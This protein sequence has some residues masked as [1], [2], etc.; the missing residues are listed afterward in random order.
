M[1]LPLHVSCLVITLLCA[2]CG[3]E[4]DHRTAPLLHEAFVWQRVWTPEV[5]AAVSTAT[6]QR[7]HVLAAEVHF[8]GV[9]PVVTTIEPNWEA[10][11]A[12]Q[13]DVGAVI[14]IHTS[15]AAT[16]WDPPACEAMTE[17]VARIW[18]LFDEAKRPA[19]EIQ[20]D[21]DC[22][23]SK[24]KDYT[25]LVVHLRQALPA[26]TLRITA[27]PSWLRHRHHDLSIYDLLRLS[28]GYVLQVHSLHLPQGGRSTGLIDYEETKAAIAR[29]VEIG[30]PFR[31]A[32]PTYSCVVE[33]AENGRVKEVHGEDMPSSL[34]LTGGQYAVL[35]SDAFALC[36]LVADWRLHAPELMQAILWYRL[37]VSTDRLNWPVE[38]LP[39]IMRGEKLKRGWSARLEPNAEGHHEVVLLQ[40]GDAPDDLPREIEITHADAADGLRGYIMQGQPPGSVILRLAQPARFGRVRPG[41]RVVAGWVRTDGSASVKILR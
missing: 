22:P 17:L 28:P 5:S 30:V 41:E 25:T 19:S 18:D 16:G 39:N 32:L 27:L 1:K 26:D 21:Y 29:A 2:G 36:D 37:P 4:A 20:I 3:R 7:L 35:D 12:F 24:L 11:R 34:S 38:V 31:V 23:E 13:G 33:Y 10:L 8:E 6:M 40:Q 15:A 14:R 9:K